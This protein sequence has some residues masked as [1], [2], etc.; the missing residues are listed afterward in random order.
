MVIRGILATA[1]VAATTASAAAQDVTNADLQPGVKMALSAIT[2][3]AELQ[4]Q[5]YSLNPF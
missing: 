4:R 1:L 5:G 2:A 3:H